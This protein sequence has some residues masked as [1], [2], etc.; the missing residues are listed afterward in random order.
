[1]KLIQ[2]DNQA[3]M[4]LILAKMDHFYMN[5]INRFGILAIQYV[6]HVKHVLTD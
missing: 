6:L 4:K 3:P 1:M 5:C 2:M